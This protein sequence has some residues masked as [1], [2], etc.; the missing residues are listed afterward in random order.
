MNGAVYVWLLYNVLRLRLSYYIMSYSTAF[1][2]VPFFPPDAIFDLTKKYL[3]DT[4]SQKVNLGQGTYR[5]GSGQPWILPS[6]KKA[7]ELIK[8][9][10]HEYLPILGLESFRTASSELVLGA[11]SEC[12]SENRVSNPKW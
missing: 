5:D 12:L 3:A 4:D 8:D 2:T 7:K 10:N 9:Q 6:V 1:S 11:N